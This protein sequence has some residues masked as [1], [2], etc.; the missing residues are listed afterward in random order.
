M[1][2]PDTQLKISEFSRD[3]TPAS[4][5]HTLPGHASSAPLLPQKRSRQNP[6]DNKVRP[7]GGVPTLGQRV[8]RSLLTRGQPIFILGL[9]VVGVASLI[10]ALIDQDDSRSDDVLAA[11]ALLS[12][13]SGG[14]AATSVKSFALGSASAD[15]RS[16][17]GASRAP[18][19]LSE[20]A[21]ASERPPA[22]IPPAG[23]PPLATYA[24]PVAVLQSA[25]ST[26]GSAA[27]QVVPASP[28]ARD[29]VL[30][31]YATP[32]GAPHSA[33]PT[34]SGSAANQV[35]PASPPAGDPLLATYATP[36][37][38]SSGSAAT[39]L[40]P[41][42]PRAG[43]PPL[44]THAAPID[45]PS[46]AAAAPGSSAVP[47][48][49]DAIVRLIKRGRDFLKE[50][51]FAAAR[52]L[53]KRAA[54]AGSAEAALALGSTYDPAIIKQLGA[55][56]VAPDLDRARKWYEIAADRGSDEA[57]DR[58]ANLNRVR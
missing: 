53:F 16:T 54:D 29:P 47:L 8:W 9:F 30:A 49:G 46:S 38:A 32:S 25:A 40:T 11:K 5:N 4:A 20:I 34:S 39:P 41:A 15:D 36:S 17:D 43:D 27:N 58:Y 28:P 22:P 50:G 19:P 44:A 10:V 24:A 33:P 7:F 31:T 12:S 1:D 56:S 26:S 3:D 13:R 21:T 55:V 42:I 18:G 51:D 37:G 14:T 45:V 2:S 48:D 57:A 6:L 23:D 35:M 52:L